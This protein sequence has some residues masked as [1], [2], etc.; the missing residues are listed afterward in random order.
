MLK[1]LKKWLLNLRLHYGN[2][3]SLFNIVSKIF[4][5]KVYKN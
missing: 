5:R 4:T 1:K 2:I 3:S